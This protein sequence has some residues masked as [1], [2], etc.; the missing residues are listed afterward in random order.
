MR[1]GLHSFS[2]IVVTNLS[3]IPQFGK[4]YIMNNLKWYVTTLLTYAVVMKFQWFYFMWSRRHENEEVPGFINVAA[5]HHFKWKRF[6]FSHG[7]LHPSLI[8]LVLSRLSKATN[9]RCKANMGQGQSLAL[10]E[11]KYINQRD[12]LPRDNAVCRAVPLCI[13]Q[14]VQTGGKCIR[15]T[16][17]SVTVSLDEKHA[18]KAVKLHL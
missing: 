7:D 11:H 1:L 16:G 8:T 12:E 17:K 15:R 2:D 18:F 14:Q 10:T 13:T 6:L 9:I 4:F 3:T 5:C